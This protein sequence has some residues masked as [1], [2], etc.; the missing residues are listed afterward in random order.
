MDK[1]PFSVN[2][3]KV[4]ILI[5]NKAYTFILFLSE[6]DR[7]H[8]IDVLTHNPD[9]CRQAVAEYIWSR[10]DQSDDQR[11]SVDCILSQN[12]DFFASLFE[13]LYRDD[14]TL[15]KLYEARIDDLDICHRFISALMERFPDV[16]NKQIE[17]AYKIQIPPASSNVFSTCGTVVNRLNTAYETIT[18]AYTN[19]SQITNNVH[20]RCETAA[21]RWNEISAAATA[22]YTNATKAA[23]WII[24]CADV[25]QR[26]F[27]I[28]NQIGNTIAT[29]IQSI[30]IPELSD[31][32]KEQLRLSYETWGKYGWTQ[33]LA[34]PIIF[35]NNPPVD[36][37]DANA[38]ALK[39]CTQ[40]DMEK[41]FLAI[42]DLPHVKK[43]DVNEAIWAFENKQYKSCALILFALIDARLIRL[44]KDEDRRKSNGYREVGK[45][46][47]YKLFNRIE[48]EQ[49]IHQKTNI[50]FSH[51]NIFSCLSTVFADGKDFKNQPHVINRNFLDHGMLIRRVTRKDCVQILL[52]Y[53]NLMNYLSIIYSKY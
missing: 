26:S 29:V 15:K 45:K 25:L 4:K 12:N 46:A 23:S 17:S 5:D 31:E 22:V 51:Q 41:L 49:N 24:E 6:G 53:Y 13:L 47:A 9:H 43:S 21:N 42:L 48:I 10:L 1:L 8:L 35:M 32:R 27:D 16:Q 3:E 39:Y 11:P 19:F 2:D 34:A 37:K 20:K 28:I 40:K 50:L 30:S 33:P 18:N 38:K 52:L 36:Q 7:S 44:Q 14:E